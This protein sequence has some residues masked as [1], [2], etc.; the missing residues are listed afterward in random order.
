M[1]ARKS[2]SEKANTARNEKRKKKV[3]KN[4]NMLDTGSKAWYNERI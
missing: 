3:E 1:H 2:K 4:G